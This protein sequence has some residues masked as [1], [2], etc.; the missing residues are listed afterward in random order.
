MPAT[1]AE[2][3]GSAN[4]SASNR[5]SSGRSSAELIAYKVL[6]DGWLLPVSIC[7]IKLG[8]TP[9]SRASARIVTSRRARSAR[10]RGPIGG[11]FGSPMC[12]LLDVCPRAVEGDTSA[13]ASL[14]WRNSY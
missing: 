10:I 7:E 4:S 6:T 5:S 11:T 2:V 14:N 1:A 13:S 9:M 12:A 8:D 3:A